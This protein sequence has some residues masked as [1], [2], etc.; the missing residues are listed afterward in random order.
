MEPTIKAIEVNGVYMAWDGGAWV[1]CEKPED[2]FGELLDL[3]YG[4]PL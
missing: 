1:I 3:L 2:P 4:R